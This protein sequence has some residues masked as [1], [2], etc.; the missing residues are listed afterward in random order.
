MKMGNK[1]FANLFRMQLQKVIYNPFFLVA[2]ILQTVAF[3]IF[4]FG[5]YKAFGAVRD[6]YLYLLDGS[7]SV[8]L[9]LLVI[10]ILSVLPMASVKDVSGQKD[11]F[12]F[13]RTSRKEYLLSECMVAVLSGFLVVCISALLFIL[14][15]FLLGYRGVGIGIMDSPGVSGYSSSCLAVYLSNSKNIVILMMRI[16]ILS[17]Y[18]AAYPMLLLVISQFTINKYVLLIG[19]FLLGKIL[20]MIVIPLGLQIYL[21]PVWQTIYYSAMTGILTTRRL[22]YEFGFHIVAIA[23]LFVLHIFVFVYQSKKS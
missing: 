7:C 19:P 13:I 1:S 23:F 12:A 10:P 3:L 17:V 11:Y 21:D 5:E 14:I 4:V 22:F 16:L 2:I 18:G 6:Q 20:S 8:G 15:L 9:G